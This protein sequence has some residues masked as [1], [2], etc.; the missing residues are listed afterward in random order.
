MLIYQKFPKEV[1]I[2]IYRWILGISNKGSI[3]PIAKKYGKKTEMEWKSLTN[4]LTTNPYYLRLWKGISCSLIKSKPFKNCSWCMNKGSCYGR[5]KYAVSIPRV[6]KAFYL[7]YKELIFVLSNLSRSDFVKFKKRMLD[8]IEILLPYSKESEYHSEI[9]KMLQKN[10]NSTGN[11]KSRVQGVQQYKQKEGFHENDVL[12]DLYFKISTLIKKYDYLPFEKLIKICGTSLFKNSVN[13]YRGHETKKLKL[14]DN[15][16]NVKSEKKALFDVMPDPKQKDLV[17]EIHKKTILTYLQEGLDNE[18]KKAVGL[19]L[20]KEDKDFIEFL[21]RK[22]V[23]KTQ[24]SWNKF[25]S[26]VSSNELMNF[27]NMY[28]G[29]K[30]NKKLLKHVRLKQRLNGSRS[31]TQNVNVKGEKKMSK[32]IIN[33][34]KKKCIGCAYFIPYLNKKKFTPKD[35]NPSYPGC[36][37]H[38]FEVVH[39]FPKK[40]AAIQ[41][42]IF[43]DNGEDEKVKEFIDSCPNAS[44]IMQ[45]ALTLTDEEIEQAQLQMMEA[46]EEKIDLSTLTMPEMKEFILEN[47]ILIKGIKDMNEMQLRAALQKYID[48]LYENQNEETDTEDGDVKVV[49]RISESKENDNDD[50]DDDNDDNE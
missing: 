41:L 24:K 22:E 7:D 17:E 26:K 2:Q 44:E 36:P 49:G 15:V 16:I 9:F 21:K 33:I 19:L 5:C 43:I 37:V 46:Q 45:V 27:V 48:E 31:K 4:N 28:C 42:R 30:V 39:A 47:E 10:L 35:C 34:P 32:L 1:S 20:G 13:I 23:L 18:L 29:C 6:S 8:K 38:S 14:I 25:Y 40:Q 3:T 12:S 50:D 11:I